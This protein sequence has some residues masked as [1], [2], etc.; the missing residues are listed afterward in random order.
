MTLLVL[1]NLSVDVP[2]PMLKVPALPFMVTQRWLPLAPSKRIVPL[3]VAPGAKPSS[4]WLPERC[5][6]TK[7]VPTPI[8]VRAV[9]ALRFRSPFDRHPAQQVRGVR[10]R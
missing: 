1:G 10:R 5:A 8:F 6:V 2:A 3:S 4:V 7:L 9:F